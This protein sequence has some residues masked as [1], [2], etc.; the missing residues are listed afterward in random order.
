STH[1]ALDYYESVGQN[2]ERAALDRFAHFA[3]FAGRDDFAKALVQRL[4]TV[5]RH[6]GELFEGNAKDEA[7][8]PQLSFPEDADD[9]ETVE[10]LLAMGYKH[11]LEASATV[12][13]WLSRSHRALRGDLAHSHIEHLA[14]ILLQHLARAPDC[15]AALQALDRLFANLHGGA[16]LAD[17]LGQHP[18]VMDALIDPAFFGALP[19]EA[20][21]S[22]SLDRT[23]GEAASYEDF[24]DRLRLFKQEQL[25]LIC[26]R[27]LS[28]TITA[29]Q[30]GEAFACLADTVI[31]R[32][33][34]AVEER[35]A[36]Q[37]GRV[38]AQHV[39]VL[40]M[41]KLGGREMTAS[42]DLDLII[43]YDHDPEQMES[44]G[45]RPLYGAQYF[46]RLTQR[47]IGALTVQTN[48]GALYP[49]DMR[50]RPSGRSGPV[51]TRLDSFADYQQN[52]AWT[53]EHMAITRARVV[54][55]T[56]DFAAKVVA[57]VRDI[58]TTPRDAEVIAADV[59]EM[60]RAIA[61]EKGEDERW[62]LKYAAG[63]LVDLE[64]IGQYL[65]LVPGAAHP[66][67]L[68]TST[69]GVFDKAWRLGILPVTEAEI[70]RPAV[71]LYQD[72][73]QILRLCLNGPFDPQ[74]ASTQMLGLLA[75]A[76]DLPD[77]AM[78]NAHLTETQERV[79]ASFVRILGDAP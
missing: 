3:G 52:E 6:Y 37:H 69:A 32:V 64:F 36:Q 44:D 54:T 21:L 41:G 10:R 19:D 57:V 58:L 34:F 2:W 18:H 77:F 4:R 68:D 15:D 47:I 74:T 59:V 7:C 11:P 48:Y 9:R 16:R 24:L 63:G 42:S 62:D 51:A 70:L 17:I 76:A 22:A 46:A 73:T 49:V 45:E 43:I 66:D 1:A 67:I 26:T 35:F 12:R 55:E 25:F 30:A 20:S 50:L 33:Q 65:Q 60:R 72:L 23:I 56:P 40:A 29:R 5:Q 53:W 31:R 38:A 75:R 28:G 13:G 78:L 79:R 71:Q 27:I 14:P 8:G 61:T 39:A